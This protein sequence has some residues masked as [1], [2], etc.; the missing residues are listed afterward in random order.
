M[1]MTN[2]RY[3][4]WKASD[5]M[6]AN[7]GRLFGVYHLRVDPKLMYDAQICRLP[8]WLPP[9]IVSGKVKDCL[10]QNKVSGILF[11]EA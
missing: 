9:I 10:Q 3:D 1:D 2:S 11:E 8:N 4:R 6:P 5:N 7:L